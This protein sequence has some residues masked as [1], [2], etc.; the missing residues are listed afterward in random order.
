MRQAWAVEVCGVAAATSV[1][2]EKDPGENDPPESGTG[3]LGRV[4]SL[5]DTG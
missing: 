2:K 1:L 4:Q 3:C 5:E